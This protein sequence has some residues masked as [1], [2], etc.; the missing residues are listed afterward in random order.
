MRHL[1]ASLVL[2]LGL[3]APAAARAG[4]YS[5]DLSRCL[6]A[7]TAEADQ[8]VLAQWIYGIMSVHPDVASIA[9][10]DD[11][12]R[13]RT[14]KQVARIFETLLTA[15]CRDETA[16][17]MRYEGSEA[18]GHSFEMLGKIAMQTLLGNPKVAAE[19]QAFVRYMDQDK[20]KAVVGAAA[21][22]APAAPE[23]PA[24]QTP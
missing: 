6:V 3:A 14:S 17:A 8:I 7:H 23:A 19:S 13:E 2:L 20:L 10:V 16:R 4:V 9:R 5:D 1:T 18:L 24:A 22:A 12:A 11:G 15:S 21:A